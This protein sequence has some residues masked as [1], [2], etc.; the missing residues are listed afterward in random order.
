[1]RDDYVSE[2]IKSIADNKNFQKALRFADVQQAMTY[3]DYEQK[4]RREL[5]KYREK[6]ERYVETISAGDYHTVGLKSNGT[7]VAVD[8]NDYGQR[9]VS[10]WRNVMI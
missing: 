3:N 1:M 6:I 5:E 4:A 9:N 10:N 7:V 8:N 2:Q